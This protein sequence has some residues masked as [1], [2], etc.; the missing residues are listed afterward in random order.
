MPKKQ[1]SK[2]GK[3]RFTEK[4]FSFIEV[5]LAVFLIAVGVV[6]SVTLLGVGLRESLDS[7]SQLTA[8]LLAQEGAELVRNIR[9]NN[10]TTGPPVTT[11]ENF[12]AVDPDNC[13]I[14]LSSAGLICGAGAANKTLYL[15]S[16]GLY[17]VAGVS[18]TKFKRKIMISYDPA[19]ATPGDATYATVTGMTIW[20]S[21]FP[22]DAEHCNT[23]TKC[24]FVEVTLTNWGDKN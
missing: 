10:W 6:A 21:S 18:P 9:D 15:D 20:G 4:G 8:V 11:F 24:S 14:G 19:A 2:K 22:A 13:I 3:N 16:D 23:T 12:P 7:R 17:D 5:M 1:Q